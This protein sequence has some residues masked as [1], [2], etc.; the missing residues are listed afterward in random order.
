MFK[1]KKSQAKHPTEEQQIDHRFDFGDLRRLNPFSPYW[2]YDRGQPIDRYYIEKF[3]ALNAQDI[4][5]NVL[6][7]GDDIYTR[8]FGGDRV[9]QI[10]VLDLPT[11]GN[12]KA[13]IFA[14][15][16]NA[17]HVPTEKFDCIVF[18]QT[19]HLIYDFTAAVRT[20]HRILRPRGVLLAT[21]PGLS[22][23]SHSEWSGSW[24]WRFSK[25]S[26][27]R[28]FEQCFNSPE[29]TVVAYGNILSA[30]AFLYGMAVNELTQKELDFH[31]PDFEVTIAVRVVKS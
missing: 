23:T 25:E 18:T 9:K 21:F 8:T 1:S 10:D 13:T 17:N 24:F 28:I 12:D 15:L 7:I 27:T 31:D 16:A 6:E 26:A 4:H 20:L 5:G 19:L 11:Q 30:I 14:D 3:L 22:K 29:L 2:G